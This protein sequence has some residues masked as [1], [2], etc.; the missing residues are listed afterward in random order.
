MRTLNRKGTR[1]SIIDCRRS[2]GPTNSR[3]GDGRHELECWNYDGIY[4]LTRESVANDPSNNDGA[5]AYEFDPVGNRSKEI[6]SLSG[7]SSGT[8]GYSA[9]DEVTSESYD[10]NGNVTA[11]GGK[12]F[13]YDSESLRKFFYNSNTYSYNMVDNFIGTPPAIDQ[14]P[15]YQYSPL[16]ADYPFE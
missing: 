3:C 11:T 13:T 15:G 6:S 10:V 16:Y 5:V 14:A 12:S 1:K 8:W 2:I 7:I 4:R 9:D